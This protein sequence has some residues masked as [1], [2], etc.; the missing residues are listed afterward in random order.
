MW[1]PDWLYES[2]PYAYALGG[3]VMV[4]HFES[5]LGYV[6]GVILLVTA[7]LIWFM[8][9]DYRRANGDSRKADWQ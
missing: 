2:L 9:R 1:L 8:R 7:C 5:S 6:S 3:L 4:Y